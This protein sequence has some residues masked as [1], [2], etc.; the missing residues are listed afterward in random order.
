MLQNEADLGQGL[1]Q[2]LQVLGLLCQPFLQQ[3]TTTSKCV[4][5][6]THVVHVMHAVLA[7][8]QVL[9]QQ[10]VAQH[11]KLGCCRACCK[12]RRHPGK[13]AV[14]KPLQHLGLGCSSEH[15]SAAGCCAFKHEAQSASL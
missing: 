13:P 1:S 4:G 7:L 10:N 12:G 2:P 5:A 8:W 14:E 11:L 9:L 6:S 3:G 15:G